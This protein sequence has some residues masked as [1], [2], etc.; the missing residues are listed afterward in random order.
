M[1]YLNPDGFGQ[2]EFRS[3]IFAE[4]N[5]TGLHASQVQQTIEQLFTTKHI[6]T[7]IKIIDS[8]QDWYI[9]ITE[10]G[11]IIYLKEKGKQE[12]N[13]VLNKN[14]YNS[15]KYWKLPI[16]IAALSVLTSVVAVSITWYIHNTHEKSTIEQNKKAEDL[17]KQLQQTNTTILH[18]VDSL[19]KID[20]K[21]D[22]S[23]K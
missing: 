7:N 20:H 14:E 18:K 4:T 1:L 6:T 13:D 2:Q 17:E 3:R 23:K 19:W 21:S 16:S 5:I 15:K 9:T 8:K 10:K 22:T 11:K 12:R